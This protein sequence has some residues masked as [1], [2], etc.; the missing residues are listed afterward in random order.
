MTI[1]DFMILLAAL[2][3][4]ITVSFAKKTAHAR[5][6]NAD[7]R[8]LSAFSAKELRIYNAHLN[9]FEVFP[10]FAAAVL[11]SELR[12]ASSLWIDLLALFF[13]GTRLLYTVAYVY[14]KPTLRSALFGLGFFSIVALF[15]LPFLR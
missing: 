12:A 4:Y 1:A 10:L 14:D 9:G 13:V 5:F 11:L 15:L 2:L 8:N 7:P 3:P 6:D